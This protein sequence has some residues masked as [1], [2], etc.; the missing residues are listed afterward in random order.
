M[1]RGWPSNQK[2]SVGTG[3]TSD[4]PT[5]V[6]T[7][8]FRHA[9]DVNKF[10]F[11]VGSGVVP[12]TAGA[13]TG[14]R[15]VTVDGDEAYCVEDA[16]TP[17]RTG[18]F[19]RFEDGP[20]AGIEIPIIKVD[21]NFIVLPIKTG[22]MPAP[23][24]EFYIMRSIT[25]RTSPDGSQLVT[26]VPVSYVVRPGGS[27]NTQSTNIDDSAYVELVAST[28]NAIAELE[29]I[30]KTGLPM[31]VGLGASGSEV[32]QF[33]IGSDGLTRQQ[34]PIPLG[35]R[36]SLKTIDGTADAGWVLLNAFGE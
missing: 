14:L 36:I 10:A 32:H 28:P 16:A 29:F 26:V 8:P 25:Q 1:I 34:I 3:I 6:P 11:R 21:G 12:R 27:I 19:V 9:L 35:S 4:F 20:A 17:A 2:I 5:V 33:Y 7:D 31:S 13:G 23:G 18:D 15:P 30:N 22:L 24:N